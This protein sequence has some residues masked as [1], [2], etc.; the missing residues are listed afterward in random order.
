MYFIA[1]AGLTLVAG[2]VLTSVPHWEIGSRY[3]SATVARL[4]VAAVA[5]ASYL[6]IIVAFRTS[7]HATDTGCE[8]GAGWMLVLALRRMDWPITDALLT[9]ELLCVCVLAG[10]TARRAGLIAM[11][12]AVLIA[13]DGAIL[14][15]FTG[16][17]GAFILGGTS[18]PWTMLLW[19][20]RKRGFLNQHHGRSHPRRARL[21]PPTYC[22]FCN[23]AA[24][25]HHRFPGGLSHSPGRL[26]H[27]DLHERRRLCRGH[28][29]QP[30][31]Q[32]C[33]DQDQLRRTH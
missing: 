4:T 32:G 23:L 19:W 16:F 5:I 6:G 9:R 20:G 3:R 12:R 21:A 18:R 11:D 10:A 17:L 13:M 7:Y 24:E 26:P 25:C 14:M 1:I 29:D 22:P 15:I 33:D 28:P 8:A 2:L 31:C 30:V 27:P